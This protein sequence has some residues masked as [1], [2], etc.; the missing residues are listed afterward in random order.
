MLYFWIIQKALDR[1][2]LNY[3]SGFTVE[4]VNISK[5]IGAYT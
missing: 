2:T 5:R 3:L 4:I 1:H